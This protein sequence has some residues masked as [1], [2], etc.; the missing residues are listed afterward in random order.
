M[1]NTGKLLVF[2]HFRMDRAA[3]VGYSLPP[4]K[5]RAQDF[6]LLDL[7]HLERCFLSINLL[8][9]HELIYKRS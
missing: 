1:A 5:K 2:D 8:W 9:Y 3:H 6:F 4:F 7:K